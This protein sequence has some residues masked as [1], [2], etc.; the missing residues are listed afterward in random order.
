MSFTIK[1]LVYSG[2]E[3]RERSVRVKDGIIETV[4]DDDVAPTDRDI[5]LGPREILLPSAIDMQ[6][7]L[8][9]WA[10]SERETVETATKAALAGGVTVV[11]DQANTVPRL[12]SADLVRKRVQYVTEH[13]YTDFG[14]SGHPP[15]N[16]SDVEAYREAGAFCIQHFPWDLR[17]WRYPRDIDDSQEK[18]RRYAELGLSGMVISGE[19]SFESTD[20]AEVAESYGVEALLRRLDPSFRVRVS[21]TQPQSVE[22][23]L[24]QKDRLPNMLIQVPHHAIF[25]DKEF[26][27]AKIG[28]ASNHIPPLR[29]VEDVEKLQEL[30]KSNIYP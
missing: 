22:T 14:I 2:G 7:A 27:Y 20:L 1:G 3:V 6:C 15:V 26:A 5:E 9:D 28:A 4:S 30:V 25:A 18:F 8:R 12:D 17:P 29:S 11:C 23:L 10:E 24:E 19:L 16:E 13:S 21:V